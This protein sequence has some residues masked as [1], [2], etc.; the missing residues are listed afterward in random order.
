MLNNYYAKSK[1]LQN[2]QYNND[3][4]TA[5]KY[6]K[7]MC[8]TTL[9][10]AIFFFYIYFSEWLPSP[11]QNHAICFLLVSFTFR[12]VHVENDKC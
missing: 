7:I 3:N 5:N 11:L 12:S 9:Y 8:K 2:K 4:K 6:A 1:V 10:T